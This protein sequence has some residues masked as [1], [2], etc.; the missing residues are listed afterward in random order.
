MNDNIQQLIANTVRGLAIDA[1]EKANSGHPGM[2]LGCADIAAALWGNGMKYDPSAPN[3][4]NRDRFVLSAGHGSMLLYAMLHLAGYN[5]SMDDLREF[6]QWGSLTPGHPEFGHTV[7]VETTTGPLGQGFA[8]GV[9]LAFAAKLLAQEFGD[10]IVN[11]YVY[12][13][14]GDGDLME[15]ISYEAASLAGHWGLGKYICIYDSNGISIEGDTNITFSENIGERFSA[16]GWHVQ[17]IDG[18]NYDEISAAITAA[19]KAEDKPSL[20]IAK[21]QI[22]KGSPNKGGSAASHG[23]PL[24]ADEALAT[25]RA[26]GLPDDKEFYVPE[27]VRAFFAQRT[28]RLKEERVEWEAK[29][30]AKVTGKKLDLWNKFFSPCSPDEIFRKLPT[31][32]DIQ[33]ISTRAAGGKVLESLFE[34]LPNIVGG[35]ADLSPSTKTFVKG[36]SE[37]GAGVVGRNIHFGVREHAMGAIQN[38]IAYYGGFL[39]YSSTFFVFMD[40]MRPSMRV[41]A[42]AGLQTIYVFTHDSFFVGEDG[43]THEPVEHL[44]AARAI[45]NLNVMRPADGPETSAAWAAA[46]RLT[47]T[48]SVI[49][50]S[51]QDLPVLPRTNNG[52]AAELSK[53][54]YII[55]AA[56][57][58]QII[59]LATGSEVSLAVAA[60]ELLDKRGIGAQVVSF[61]SWFL[62]DGQSLEYKQALLP[63]GAKYAVVEA[64][65]AMGWEKY[66][67][68]DALF[69]TLEHF[70]A[71]A[72]AGVLAEQFGF[73]PQAVADKIEAYLRG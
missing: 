21:T 69:I 4:A 9:G 73:S 47:G 37:T 16:C 36:A 15:G 5:I 17:T 10:G 6:R 34:A 54:A 71:S 49:C 3:W 59:V 32:A 1:I 62:F 48:P 58:P 11:H 25:K 7:G 27:D 8:N 65:R 24:G 31:F 57:S 55:R 35:S 45:P 42:L 13:L 70:G 19:Q 23:A 50:L 56:A 52:G 44:A 41:A 33:K 66:A 22:A 26:L 46:L 14:A 60:A 18:H 39:P 2:P 72:P 64:G 68:N 38:G 53:G 51:R 20:I 28:A 67:G 63:A 12:A 43:P 61:P 29:F 40:Y 30:A